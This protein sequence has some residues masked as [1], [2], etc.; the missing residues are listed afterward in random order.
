MRI[1]IVYGTSHGQ[2]RK[3]VDFLAERLRR[4]ALVEVK[5]AGSA[6][7][8]D[9]ATFDATII[10]SSMRMGAYRPA[11]VRF[12]RQHVAALNARPSAF[13]SVTMA[14]ANTRHHEQAIAELQK[15]LD[16]FSDKSGWI[17]PRIEH[18]AGALAYTR[19][20]FFTRWIMR[21]IAAK[22]GNATDTSRD[23]EYTDWDGLARFANSFVKSLDDSVP[24]DAAA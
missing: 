15:W 4:S 9:P 23:H 13:V 22:E 12:V 3:V 6:G 14:A 1:L 2:T 8:V 7:D 21:R 18:V 19:Y 20:D 10:A 16:R 11:V 17:P 5:E 24:T